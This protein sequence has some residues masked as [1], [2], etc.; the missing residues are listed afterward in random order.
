MNHKALI[1]K[2]DRLNLITISDFTIVLN[3]L[4][5]FQQIKD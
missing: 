1:S 4:K 5:T 3:L 2:I